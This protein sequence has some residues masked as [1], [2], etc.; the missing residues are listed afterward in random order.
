MP[1]ERASGMPS[2]VVNIPDELTVVVPP[3]LL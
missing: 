3:E 1:D 2:A